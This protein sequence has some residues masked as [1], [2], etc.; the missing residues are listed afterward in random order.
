MSA[1]P[2]YR[3]T[4]RWGQTN[5]NEL[6]PE[7]Y[8]DGFW[9][10]YWRETRTQGVIVNAGGIVSFYPSAEPL[11]YRAVG[12]GDRDLYGDIV[13]S[14]REEGLAVIARMDSNRARQEFYDRHP[15]WFCHD[16]NGEP[17]TLT[18]LYVACLNGPYYSEYLPKIMTEVIDRSAP[19]GFADN[20]WAGHGRD[21][22]CH[23][24]NCVRWFADRYGR[25]L[26]REK[27]W[28]SETYRVWLRASLDRRIEQWEANTAATTAAG[29]PDC[30]WVGMINGELGPQTGQLHDVVEIAKRTP[31]IFLD[32]QNRHAS[33][34]FHGNTTA[35]KALHQL[36]GWDVLVPE[37]TAHYDARSPAYRLVSKPEAEVR[38]WAVSGF[39]GGIQPWWHQLGSTTEDE[40]RY[41]VSAP[42]YGWHERNEAYLVDREPDHRVGIA[43]TQGNFLFFGRDDAER[44][45]T[46]P[47]RGAIKAALH[48]RIPHLPVNLDTIVEQGF[49]GDV[50]VVPSV[51]SLSDAHLTALEQLSQRGVGLVFIGRVGEVDEWGEPRDRARLERLLG[52]RFTG[53]HEGDDT[54]APTNWDDFSR[55]SYLRLHRSAGPAELFTAL[56]DTALVAFG[57]RLERVVAPDA[58]PLTFV[59]GIRR[60]P[61]E[62]SWLPTDQATDDAHPAL[63][64][65]EADEQHGR[66]AYLA[67][68]LDRSFE[69]DGVVDHGRVLAALMRWASPNPERYVVRGPGVIAIDPYVQPGRLV[70]HLVNHS[71]AGDYRTPVTE[72]LEIGPV[73][74][75]VPI[76]DASAVRALVANSELEIVR[77]DE[78]STTV[79]VPRIADHEVVVIEGAL[80]RESVGTAE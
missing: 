23:C 80:A 36:A 6:D 71:V 50:L 3:R 2:W 13:R 47:Y 21:R 53:E 61:V 27:D 41:R 75:T 22:I 56:D 79:L 39:A 62:Q 32:H 9:R 25:E 44:L 63:V 66:I 18:G 15:D 54:P 14:A 7:R 38:L 64:V 45:V 49:D 69:R 72:F 78:N 55:H 8:D 67:A 73:E 30:V 16:V 70:V 31:I 19:D 46:E 65:R 28:A 35:G 58:A 17:F 34:S 33:N 76:R 40:R 42:L 20:G 26:P 57:G 11:Q 24:A 77:R 37:S 29:G 5:L 60:F 68:D 4:L 48:H 59:P 12:L 10:R 52:V 43:W 1:E 51:A 74:L